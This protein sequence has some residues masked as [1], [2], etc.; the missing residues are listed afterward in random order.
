MISRLLLIVMCGVYS[1][2]GNL[3]NCSNVKREFSKISEED[4][5]PQTPIAG[6]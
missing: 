2:V 3:D 6:K 1:V 5:V 4:L